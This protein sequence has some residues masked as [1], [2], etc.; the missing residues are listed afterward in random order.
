MAVEKPEET[1][2]EEATTDRKIATKSQKLHT[3]ALPHR[4]VSDALKL[5]ITSVTLDTP[6]GEEV[7]EANSGQQEVP[8]MF[9]TE[10]NSLEINGTVTIPDYLPDRVFPDDECDLG[11]FPGRLVVVWY[12]RPTILRDSVTVQEGDTGAGSYEFSFTLSRGMVRGTV[13]VAPH[14]VRADTRSSAGTFATEAGER[15][16]DGDKWRILIDDDDRQDRFLHPIVEKFSEHEN[17]PSENHLYW[18]DLTEPERPVLYLNGDHQ[19]IVNVTR[20]KGTTGG[21]ARLRDVIFDHIEH[22]VWT[23]LII[24]TARDIDPDGNPR[25]GWQEDVISKFYGDLYDDA[26][27]ETTALNLRDDIRSPDSIESLM[28][29]IDRS[30]QNELNTPTQLLNLIEEGL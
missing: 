27:W 29:R 30:L 25:H 7:I 3:S 1:S 13:H 28:K 12:C 18:L 11:D 17:F 20:K 8:V 19:A 4:F 22:S 14:L 16:A 9:D 23:Q 15:L 21:E 26:D 6:K 24:R 5:D 10:W 2:S